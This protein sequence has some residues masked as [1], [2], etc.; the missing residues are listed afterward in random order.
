MCSWEAARWSC[1][2]LQSDPWLNLPGIYCLLRMHPNG[3]IGRLNS[4][5]KMKQIASSVCAK[6]SHVVPELP[7]LCSRQTS[8]YLILA[9]NRCFYAK[10]C[11]S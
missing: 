9:L 4:S 7:G 8:M 10:A 1:Q 11:G 2:S 3:D 6:L 5:V